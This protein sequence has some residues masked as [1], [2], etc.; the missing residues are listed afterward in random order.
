MKLGH[1]GGRG[2]GEKMGDKTEEDEQEEIK[3]RKIGD[4]R[5]G[6]WG[7]GGGAEAKVGEQEESSKNKNRDSV[8]N[9]MDV[10]TSVRNVNVQIFQCD[11]R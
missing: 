11:R 1:W 2:G 6:G 10:F 3:R 9:Q 7:R 5:H 8:N 4:M